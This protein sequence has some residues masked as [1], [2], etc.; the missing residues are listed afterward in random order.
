MVKIVALPTKPEDKSYPYFKNPAKVL[1][2]S[3]DEVL[4]L[5]VGQ[6]GVYHLFHYKKDL[7]KATDREVMDYFNKTMQM[8]DIT[9]LSKKTKNVYSTEERKFFIRIIHQ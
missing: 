6:R 1:E 2:I 7:D 4:K 8:D 5:T 9:L 3:D